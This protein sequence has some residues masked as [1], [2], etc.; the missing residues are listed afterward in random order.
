MAFEPI[1]ATTF[2][3][4]IEDEYLKVVKGD[5]DTTWLILSPNSKK[6]YEPE[7]TGQGFS[8]FLHSFDDSKVQYGL[9]RVSPP[10]S[11]VQKLILIGWCPDS[12]PLK[13]RSSFAQ[14]FGLIAN[15]VLKTY[16]VQVTARDDDD[17]DEAELL[18]KLSNSAGARYSIQQTEKPKPTS[19][20]FGS[21]ATISKPILKSSPSVGPSK[22]SATEPPAAGASV[23]VIKAAVTPVKKNSFEDGWDEPELQER[24]FHKNPLKANESAWKPIGKVDLQKV[25]ASEKSKEDPRLVVT[26]PTYEKKINPQAEITKLKEESRLKRDAEYN[27]VLGETKSTFSVANV[28]K[29]NDELN[30]DI[31]IKKTPAQIW[32]E[33]KQREQETEVA[34]DAVEVSKPEDNVEKSFKDMKIEEPLVIKPSHNIVKEARPE[35][36]RYDPSDSWIEKRKQMGRPLPTKSEEK[37]NDGGDDDDNDDNDEDWSDDESKTPEDLPSLPARK[38]ISPSPSQ[39]EV[40][41]PALPVRRNISTPSNDDV[42]D[43]H[44]NHKEAEF[45]VP[46]TQNRVAS[47]QSSED[48]CEEL[49]S[50]PKRNTA[51][52]P[53]PPSRKPRA[54]KPSTPA[55]LAEYDYEAAEDNELTFNEGDK[56]VNIQFVDDD[57]W[58]GELEKSGEKGLFPSN[59]VSLFK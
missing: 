19:E 44:D 48:E 52:V 49:P 56:I 3:R 46:P 40:E 13:T 32:A 57:W 21:K 15:Q 53:P 55:A 34:E 28:V 30:H 54:P 43:S 8:E 50:L 25:I 10:G 5:S 22:S 42:V 27:K 18:M 9:A 11:D 36:I 20:R 1:D 31:Q 33:R 37:Q 4:E 59:Y 38:S 58:L 51:P 23:S 7:I 41:A 47:L 29:N 45:V 16:H 17:L 14:N 6:Q 39:S 24:D 35:T 2:S 12:A 26:T